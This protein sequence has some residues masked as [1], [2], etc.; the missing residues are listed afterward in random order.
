V[1]AFET[2]PHAILVLLAFEKGYSMLLLRLS[3]AAYRLKRAIGIEAVYSCLLI[4]TRGITAGSGF[5][6]AELK[7]LLLTL[8]ELL[9]HKWAGEL[10][11]KLYVDDLTITVVGLPKVVVFTMIRVI[12]F[13]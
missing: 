8:M 13:V 5:A 3:I 12:G 10:I 1:K 9:H 2:V 4:A 6:T 7:A 11:L